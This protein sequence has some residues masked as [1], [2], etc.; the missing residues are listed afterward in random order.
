MLVK[1]A[2]LSAK[3]T[4]GEGLEIHSTEAKVEI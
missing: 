4:C 1:L 2:S 3:T